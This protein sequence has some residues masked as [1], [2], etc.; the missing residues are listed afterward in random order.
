MFKRYFFQT[1][2]MVN[3]MLAGSTLVLSKNKIL[4]LIFVVIL[5][6]I[7]DWLFYYHNREIVDDTIDRCKKIINKHNDNNYE[8]Q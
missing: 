1:L 3:Y 2:I 7:G 4:A 6:Y 5:G 8:K